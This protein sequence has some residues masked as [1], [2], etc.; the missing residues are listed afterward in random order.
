MKDQLP[1][2][3][4]MT[5]K[6]ILSVTF[7]P[8][9]VDGPALSGL[10]DGQMTGTSG[11]AVAPVSPFPRSGHERDSKT[12]A[13][14]GRNSSVSSRR[15]ALQS[16]L[17]NSL[18][19]RLTGSDL[20]EVTWKPW[21]SPWGQSLS[22]PRAQVRTSL[23]T[24]FGLWPRPTS[25]SFAASHQP[26]NSR[27]LNLIR[28]HILFMLAEKTTGVGGKMANCGALTPALIGWLMGYPIEWEKSAAF[29][30]AVD[31]RPAAAVVGAYLDAVA[32]TDQG[33]SD[34]ADLDAHAP[35]QAYVRR[36]NP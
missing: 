19:T 14:Y 10:R 13:T 11:P 21:I 1:M 9:S 5:S 20:C 18:R 2:S 7:S 25:L 29:G 16:S 4:Q 26:G 24:D 12:S 28:S 27:N 3:N 22:R 23:V 6:D 36:F 15:A 31:P 30:N 35:N 32:D 17:E 33:N 8:V 34:P